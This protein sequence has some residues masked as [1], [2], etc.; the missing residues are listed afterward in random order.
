[1]RLLTLTTLLVPALFSCASDHDHSHEPLVAV[2]APAAPGLP[3]PNADMDL[4]S[5]S[6]SLNVK[7]IRAS[8]AFYENLGFT[9][10]D[11]DIAQ[12]WLILQNGA[13]TIGIFQDTIPGNTLTF[14]PGWANNKVH[15]DE[16][17]DI[18]ELQ[19]R[20]KAKGME[21]VLEADESTEGPAFL[22]LTDPDGN[23]I[24]LDQHR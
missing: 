17:T 3:A 7:D 13:S 21:F 12:N 9:K 24:L 22:M 14:N 10:I 15:P 16:F 20:L 8:R 4:G 23:A 18:R 19:R 5:F 11:G 2:A 6:I 1:M